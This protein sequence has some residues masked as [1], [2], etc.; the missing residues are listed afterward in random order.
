MDIWIIIRI[1][2]AFFFVAFGLAYMVGVPD[3]RALIG[4]FFVALGTT[5]LWRFWIA[6]RTGQ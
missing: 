4:A 3:M 2:I 1:F 6:I 5:F